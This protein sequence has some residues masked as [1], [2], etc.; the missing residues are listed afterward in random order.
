MQ[1]HVAAHKPREIACVGFVGR[2][3]VVLPDFCF[4]PNSANLG[5]SGFAVV[6]CLYCDFNA[7]RKP[8]D[9]R[10]AFSEGQ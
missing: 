3:R 6:Q 4:A 7:K 1:R 9:K 10:V 2:G 5:G 8:S